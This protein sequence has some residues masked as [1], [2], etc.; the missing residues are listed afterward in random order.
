MKCGNQSYQLQG[1]DRRRNCADKENFGSF[2]AMN[3]KLMKS[4]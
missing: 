4:E 3:Q 2:G 1:D